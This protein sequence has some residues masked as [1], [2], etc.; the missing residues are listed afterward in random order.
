MVWNREE[1]LKAICLLEEGKNYDEI[2][3]I[4]LRTKRSIKEK[5]NKLG[6][7]QLDYND[8]RYKIIEKCM[9]C[10]KEYKS[11]ITDNRTFCSHSCSTSYNNINRNITHGK[12]I[13]KPC[14]ICMTITKNINF[15][16]KDCFFKQ[17]CN[18]KK[19]DIEKGLIRHHPTLRKYVF[20]K[21]GHICYICKGT[22]WNDVNIPLV[23]DHID[24]NPYNNMPDNLRMICNNCD[25]LTDTYKS[26]NIGKGRH[27]R[28]KRYKD[29]KSY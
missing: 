25:A 12:F 16:S 15:C 13:L 28:M 11:Y 21:C 1:I 27:E 19:E 18:Q 6:Y 22:K 3:K 9:K 29:G 26:K 8:I 2:S 4:L 10:E 20:E 7:K 24:G 23:L 5:L 17:K 14:T